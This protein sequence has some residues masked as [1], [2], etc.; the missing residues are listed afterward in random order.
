MVDKKAKLY[1][2]K[3]LPYKGSFNGPVQS[4]YEIIRVGI[5]QIFGAKR[6]F[7]NKILIISSLLITYV[8][9]II[10]VGILF[11]AP[12]LMRGQM[13]IQESIPNL[14]SGISS[15]VI[16]L[17]GASAALLL[18]DD[19]KFHVTALYFSRSL[20]RRE[21]LFGKIGAIAIVLLIITLGPSLLLF[22]GFCLRS[23][24]P[25]KYFLT[26]LHQLEN[27]FLTSM[28]ETIFLS[29]ISLVIASFI[30]ERN[31]AVGIAVSTPFVLT[32]VMQMLRNNLKNDIFMFFS[33]IDLIG[34]FNSYIFLGKAGY[35]IKLG[36]V[37][38]VIFSIAA[39]LFF[40]IFYR[41]SKVER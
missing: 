34:T 6:P 35:A 30:K 1:E 17:S 28:V 19:R 41:Y 13:R 8:P 2:E 39:F 37:I 5:L 27:I 33:P 36:E 3:Y 29:S 22:V 11:L 20:R 4:I 23:Y 14:M 21:Y 38:L 31:I 15:I 9:A 12:P 7:K 25:L 16:I 10:M 40:L 32:A 26:H 24:S 18:C